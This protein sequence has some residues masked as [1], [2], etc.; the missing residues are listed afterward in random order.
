MPPR[1]TQESCSPRVS[2][3]TMVGTLPSGSCLKG[4][5]VERP[6]T[7]M[8]PTATHSPPP[9]SCLQG[10]HA[11]FWRHGEIY[12]NQGGL[13]AGQAFA[14][15][16]PQLFDEFPVGYSLA[17]CSPAE[18]ASASPTA[19]ILPQQASAVEGASR[20]NRAIPTQGWM[21]GKTSA[22]RPGRSVFLL[23]SPLIEPAHKTLENDTNR[24][25]NGLDISNNESKDTRTKWRTPST[26]STLLRN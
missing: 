6:P 15:P 11:S 1:I 17:S 19:S 16:S 10:G 3:R 20:I 5:R 26:E 8:K 12:R 21:P 9:P 4:V 7:V 25:C 14:R 22:I 2:D 13:S 24:C 23:T 18:L